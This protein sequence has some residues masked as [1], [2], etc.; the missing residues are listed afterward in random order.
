MVPCP[1]FPRWSRKES[2]VDLA[3]MFGK[4]ET[5]AIT[6]KEKKSSLTEVQKIVEESETM[7]QEQTVL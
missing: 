2:N 4:M 7:V 6:S 1:M 3:G 5:T